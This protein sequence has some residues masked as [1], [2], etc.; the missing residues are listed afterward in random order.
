MTVKMTKKIL[1]DFDLRPVRHYCQL[2]IERTYKIMA[3]ELYVVRVCVIK[4][5]EEDKT[6]NTPSYKYPHSSGLE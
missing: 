6:Q 2:A 1:I 4:T 3:S 5:T